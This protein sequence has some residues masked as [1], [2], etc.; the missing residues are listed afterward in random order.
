[1]LDVQNSTGKRNVF[2][3]RF[4][5]EN[6]KIVTNDIVSLGMVPVFNFRVEF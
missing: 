1:M 2:K 3:R 6:G 5:F 4:T